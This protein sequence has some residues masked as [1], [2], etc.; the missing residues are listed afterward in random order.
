MTTTHDMLL[1]QKPGQVTQ[2]GV[3]PEERWVHGDDLC[4]CTFQRIQEFTNPYIGRTLRVR[5]CCMW[6]EMYKQFPQFVQDIPAFNDYNKGGGV[7]DEWVNK[8]T[9]WN[10]EDSDMPRALWHRQVAAEMGMPLGTV[11]RLL[12][13]QAPPKAVPGSGVRLKAQQ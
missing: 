10:A 3:I 13:G 7:R 2:G 1:M 12:E 5:L 11:R 6:A 4:D 9:A 8:P